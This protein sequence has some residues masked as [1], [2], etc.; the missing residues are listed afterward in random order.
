MKLFIQMCNYTQKLSFPNYYSYKWLKMGSG[1]FLVSLVG[2]EFIDE[3]Y[4]DF[5]PNV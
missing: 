3:S 2:S 1:M 4:G 5:H